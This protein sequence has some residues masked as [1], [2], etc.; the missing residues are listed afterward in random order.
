MNTTLALSVST[1]GVILD[2]T[3]GTRGRLGTEQ[4]TVHLAEST[5]CSTSRVPSVCQHECGNTQETQI[6]YTGHV[7]ELTE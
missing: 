6:L 1:V 7:T 2:K 5:M 3:T 4:Y